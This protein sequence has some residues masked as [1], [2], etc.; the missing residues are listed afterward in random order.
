MNPTLP[1]TGTAKTKPSSPVALPSPHRPRA[2]D[3]AGYLATDGLV[4][5]INVALLLGKPLLL[6]GEPGTGKTQLANRIAWELGLEPLL[7][8]ETKSTSTARDLF[9]TF[10]A[11]RRFHAAHTDKV[12]SDNLPYITYNA[13][14][15]AILAANPLTAV[16][17][18][19]PPGS[20]HVGP[21]RSVV[22]IDEV[23]KAP[24]DFP[25]DLLNEVEH[26][27]FRVPELGNEA[28][29]A[30]PALRPIVIITSNSEKNLP[31][32]F[33]RRCVYYHIPFPSSERLAEI[34]LRRVEYFNDRTS[35]LLDSALEL[36]MELRR[37]KLDKPPST[38]ELIDWLDVLGRSGADPRRPM[39][40][41]KSQLLASLSALLKNRDDALTVEQFVRSYLNSDQTGEP[42]GL[43][44]Q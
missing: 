37:L 18:F 1:F 5:A 2:T 21:R 9:Y 16:T 17:R 14:G 40:E 8:F 39:R 13:L 42:A 7:V 19:L 10:D 24:R 27:Y 6:T 23:D 44:K 32:P 20:A 29:A 15:H 25:N 22:L 43:A 38:A 11:L 4:Q 35:P 41:H 28:I 30:E 36:F 3:P 34:V 33:L 12:N 26:M 31:D